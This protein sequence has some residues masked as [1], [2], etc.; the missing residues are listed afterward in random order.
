MSAGAKPGE[1]RGG[2]LPGV[3][4]KAT[5]EREAGLEKALAKAF[6]LLGPETIDHLDPVEFQQIAW[7]AAA[8]AGFI[9]PALAIAREVSQ[10]IRAKPPPK[11]ESEDEDEADIKI[12]GGL[13]DD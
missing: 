8:K 3:K 6:A 12:I 13:P 7:R 2:R 9:R 4:N 10:Y 1:R 11:R 5:V